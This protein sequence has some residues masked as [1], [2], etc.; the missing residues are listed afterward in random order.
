EARPSRALH[1]A[2]LS[3]REGRRGAR[4]ARPAGGRGEGGA[5]GRLTGG[6]ARRAVHIADAIAPRKP[7][8]VASATVAGW[9]NA[10]SVHALAHTSATTSPTYAVPMTSRRAAGIRK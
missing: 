7:S 9:C 5:R 3:A 8:V 1:L 2:T 6:Y 10:W 4:R